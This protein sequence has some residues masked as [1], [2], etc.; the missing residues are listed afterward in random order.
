MTTKH[1]ITSGFVTQIFNENNE[2]IEQNFT[3]GCEV[4]Y[5]DVHGEPIEAWSEYL[6]FDMVQPIK[7][8][9]ELIDKAI[10]QIKKD[11]AMGD[12][13]AIDELLGFIPEQYLKGYL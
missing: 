7:P 6:P 12:V 9:Q 1:K 13:T 8:N 10:E 5:E 3:A 11:I 4:D 2:P